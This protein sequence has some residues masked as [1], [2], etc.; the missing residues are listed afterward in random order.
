M[1]TND[2]DISLDKSF[3]NLSKS[4]KL[5]ANN[6]ETIVASYN[7]LNPAAIWSLKISV[8]YLFWEISLS[9]LI[10]PFSLAIILSVS[11]STIVLFK[12][13]CEDSSDTG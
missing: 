11:S 2:L 5:Y 10:L 8:S 3:V 4:C 6:V 9:L 7:L 12:S 13:F 1:L